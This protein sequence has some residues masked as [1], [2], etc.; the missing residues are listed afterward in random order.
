MEK[1][2]ESDCQKINDE[3]FFE[4]ISNKMT[5]LM[6]NGFDENIAKIN[7]NIENLKKSSN[8]N[9]ERVLEKYS[10][11]IAILGKLKELV[12]KQNDLQ[13]ESVIL[14]NKKSQLDDEINKLLCS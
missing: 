13:K 6:I 12:K 14:S 1:I 8:A 5:A 7:V 2:V 11:E 10:E 4:D 9:K 3:D